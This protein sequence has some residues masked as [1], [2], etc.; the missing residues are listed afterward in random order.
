MLPATGEKN[1]RIYPNIYLYSSMSRV[2][3]FR[4]TRQV[5]FATVAFEFMDSEILLLWMEFLFVPQGFQ[6]CSIRRD[7]FI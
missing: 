7:I 1:E 2:D 3:P 6:F 4:D 5:G